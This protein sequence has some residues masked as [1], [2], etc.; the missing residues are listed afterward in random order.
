MILKRKKKLIYKEDK[1]ESTSINKDK[2][3]IEQEDYM[4]ELIDSNFIGYKKEYDSAKRKIWL[5]KHHAYTGKKYY[6]NKKK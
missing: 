5:P 4:E 6:T 1:T 2:L 3:E